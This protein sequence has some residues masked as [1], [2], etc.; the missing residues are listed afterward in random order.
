V[1]RA[2]SLLAYFSSRQVEALDLLRRLVEVDSPTSDKQAVD[3]L[4][5]LVAGELES[6]G[7]TITRVTQAGAGDLLRAAFGPEPSGARPA[8][9]LAH[10]DTVWPAGEAARRPFR[11]ADG[12]ATGPGVYDMKAGVVL[13]LMLARAARDGAFEP[14]LPVVCLLSGD[15]EAG[16][17]VSRP[18]IED[19]ARGC[20]YVLGLEPSTP[21]G[22]A[23]TRRKGV[24]RIRLEVIGAPA[25]TGIDPG[26]GVNA[27]EE[28]AAQILAVKTLHDMAAGTSIHAGIVR[29]GVAR[30]VVAPGATVEFDVRVTT[31]AEWDRVEAGVRSLRPHHPG[32]RLDSEVILSHPP[33]VRT[34]AV[35]S[36]YLQARRA[37]G[38]IGFDLG[39]VETGGGSDGSLCAAVGAPVLDGLGVEGDG[40]HAGHEQIRIDRI[41]LRAAFLAR[42]LETVTGP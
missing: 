16:S 40:A 26:K 21:L 6:A 10:L 41:A 37:A 20:A 28:V 23:K 31:L 18:H 4:G 35:A 38:E 5:A 8:L 27:I 12:I 42:I 9:L 15:E 7:A 22:E 36:L 13:C 29:G 2:C 17:P 32:A 25:H 1:S 24:G 34:D 33:M 11:I 30:N 3:R 14:G 19:A 39:E